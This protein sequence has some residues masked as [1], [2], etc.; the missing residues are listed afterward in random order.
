MA[1]TLHS[2]GFSFALALGVLGAS[3]APSAS[4]GL[5]QRLVAAYA[6]DVHGILGMQRHFS[7]V[8][9][10][11]PVHHT[12]DSD[13]G[14]LID[15]GAYV[16]I[17]YYRIV[18]DGRA[19]SS[20]KIAQRD[21]QTNGDWAAGKVFFKEPYDRRYAADYTFA[22]PGTAA[23]CP[24]AT[25]AVNFKSAVRDIQH[26]SGTM[27][28]LTSSERV[29]KLTYVPNAFPPHASAGTITETSAEVLPGVWYVTR[30][31]ETFSGHAFIVH[32]TATF[33]GVVDHFKRFTTIPEGDTAL[34]NRM[35]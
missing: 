9:N 10:A 13:S 3:P 34:E 20:G 23:A 16:K 21:S 31:D 22:E 7:T 24:A 25:I 19:F 26:G 8:I 5:V 17:K 4:P 12:E 6:A 27:C 14:L 18:E 2:L 11:G 30:I 32:G 29:V 1:R 35:I 33:T 28:V 15:D